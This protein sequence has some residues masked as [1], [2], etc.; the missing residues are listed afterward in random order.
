[1]RLGPAVGPSSN[2]VGAP[3]PAFTTV[4]AAVA[5]PAAAAPAAAAATIDLVANSLGPL[6]QPLPPVTSAAEGGGT[7]PLAPAGDA[8]KKEAD[9][10][11]ARAAGVAHR[12]HQRRLTQQSALLVLSLRRLYARAALQ[13]DAKAQ[14][15]RALNRI[16]GA[17]ATSQ[18]VS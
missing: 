10:A 9:R 14:H 15:V 3:A 7:A 4:A 11:A 17:F 12:A 16:F 6:L 5:A 1:M 2:A 13:G 8:T 18:V